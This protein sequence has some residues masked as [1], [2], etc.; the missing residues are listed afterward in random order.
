MNGHAVAFMS[1]IVA[2][3]NVLYEPAIF[4]EIT[5]RGAYET[6]NDY[7]MAARTYRGLSQTNVRTTYANWT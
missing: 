7:L 6:G 4:G 2:I 3:C 1:F 5:F